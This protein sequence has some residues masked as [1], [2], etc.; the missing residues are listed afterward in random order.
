MVPSVGKLTYSE[1]LQNMLALLPVPQK[2]VSLFCAL[3]EDSV[4]L[5]AIRSVTKSFFISV[6]PRQE[7]KRKFFKT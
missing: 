4:G 1:W 5:N 3:V 6:Y 7:M 2:R